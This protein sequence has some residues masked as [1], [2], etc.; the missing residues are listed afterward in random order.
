MTRILFENC[1][2]LILN[3]FISYL[4]FKFLLSSINKKYRIAYI[5][6]GK[7]VSNAILLGG[8]PIIFANTLGIVWITRQLP[9]Q[10]PAYAWLVSSIILA[11]G[12][13]IDDKKEIRARYKLAFQIVSV[14]SFSLFQT[15]HANQPIY[16]FFAYSFAGMAMVNG[17]NLLDGLD[18]MAIKINSVII[19]TF[20]IT[21][22]FIKDM[23]VLLFATTGLTLLWSFYP[24]NKYPSKIHLGEV[25][26]SYL[27]FFAFFLGVTTFNNPNSVKLEWSF[28]LPILIPML[29]LGVSFARRLLSGKSPFRGDQLHLHHILKKRYHLK[30][31]QIS[32]Y[33]AIYLLIT[34]ML[35]LAASMAFPSKLFVPIYMAIITGTYTVFCYKDW[36]LFGK[37][38]HS[39]LF[40]VINSSKIEYINAEQ[41]NREI[42]DDAA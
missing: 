23:Q 3:G 5:P 6:A 39:N 15:L 17:I 1:L 41:I 18:T 25:G 33:M 34:T 4:G 7:S 20:I 8:L 21:A 2:F 32:N 37:K 24:F 30:P 12:G 31:Q 11:M 14:C 40:Y 29:E 28:L 38:S 22:A 42:M 9:N 10:A 27:G 19:G 16:M 13:W 36:A 26:S 35:T